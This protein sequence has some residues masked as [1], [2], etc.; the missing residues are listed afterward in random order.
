MP[1]LSSLEWAL[2]RTLKRELTCRKT[3]LIATFSHQSPLMSREIADAN[4]GCIPKECIKTIIYSQSTLPC[5]SISPFVLMW[6]RTCMTSEVIHS[7]FNYEWMLRIKFAKFNCSRGAFPQWKLDLT[8]DQMMVVCHRP[9]FTLDWVR[10]YKL[11]GRCGI[12]GTDWIIAIVI[13]S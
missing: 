4:D 7:G 11:G 10:K 1:L 6:K 9:K 3:L 5:L 2:I 13:C 12:W 8:C